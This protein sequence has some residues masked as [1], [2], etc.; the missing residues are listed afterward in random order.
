MGAKSSSKNSGNR[1]GE[2]ATTA[3]KQVTDML[4]IDIA[5]NA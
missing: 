4:K 1:L 2:A 5:I 3:R